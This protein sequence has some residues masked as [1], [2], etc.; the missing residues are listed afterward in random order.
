MR[1]VLDTNVLVS[2]VFFT[3][4]PSTI[5]RAWRDR[6]IT[7]L[8]SA[9]ILEEYGRVARELARKFPSVRLDSILTLLMV[10]AEMVEAPSLSEKV[11]EDPEDDKF[12]ACALAGG[13]RLIIS[14]DRLLRKTSGYRGI[15][16]LTPGRFVKEF[17]KK[18]RP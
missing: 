8:I 9:P 16:V 17:L 4:P 10:K 11:C 14:G 18:I 7:L 3:G 2:G 5:L 12:L 15:R 13:C 1:V 6:R